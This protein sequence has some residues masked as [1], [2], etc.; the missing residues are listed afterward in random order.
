MFYVTRK[1]LSHRNHSSINTE[2]TIFIAPFCS[3]ADL[4]STSRP[5]KIMTPKSLKPTLVWRQTAVLVLLTSLVTHGWTAL[6]GEWT[7]SI[8]Q[9]LNGMSFTGWAWDDT[10]LRFLLTLHQFGD[11]TLYLSLFVPLD[12]VAWLLKCQQISFL[13]VSR[14]FAGLLGLIIHCCF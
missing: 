5:Q 13:A 1:I 3:T 2:A 7:A 11:N 6:W 14:L 8:G 9:K 12:L 4:S 10:D